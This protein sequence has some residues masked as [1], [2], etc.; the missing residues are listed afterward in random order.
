[1]KVKAKKLF[2]VGTHH[3][4][5]RAG[6]TAEIVGTSMVTPPGE[7]SEPRPCF[8]V[9]FDDGRVDFVPIFAAPGSNEKNPH[10]ELITA[11]DMRAGRIPEVAH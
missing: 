1:M 8:K 4:S 6:E 11:A 3:D 9:R 2:L 7:N 10:Y 5:F